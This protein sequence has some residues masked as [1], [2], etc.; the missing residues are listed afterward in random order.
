MINGRGCSVIR[1][2]ICIAAS[3]IYSTYMNLKVSKVLG[4]LVKAWVHVH[5]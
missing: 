5:E 1:N 4:N 2:A 3:A